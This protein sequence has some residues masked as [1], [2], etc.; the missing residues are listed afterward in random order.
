LSQEKNTKGKLTMNRT[1]SVGSVTSMMARVTIEQEEPDEIQHLK[2]KIA[3]QEAMVTWYRESNEKLMADA[4]RWNYAKNNYY[5]KLGYET[6][7]EVQKTVDG[8]M[9]REK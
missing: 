4:A 7:D 5:K 6:P 1:E 2:E 3:D 9:G 8:D